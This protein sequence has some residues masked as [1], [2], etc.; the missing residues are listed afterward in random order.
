M[1]VPHTRTPSPHT[2]DTIGTTDTVT[3]YNGPCIQHWSEQRIFETYWG[4][5]CKC[6]LCM[7]NEMRR[8]QNFGNVV[9]AI[10]LCTSYLG[11][12][13]ANAGLCDPPE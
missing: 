1:S 3:I 8:D 6:R 2:A 4:I 9:I 5:S 13:G 10:P 11:L 7:E 12:R